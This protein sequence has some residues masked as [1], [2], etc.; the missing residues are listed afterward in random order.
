MATSSF[1]FGSDLPIGVAILAVLIGILGALFLIGAVILFLVLF[2]ASSFSAPAL[3]F[4]GSTFIGALLLLI[5]GI[6]LLVV[7][8]GLWDLELWAL[9]LSIIVVGIAFIGELLQGVSQIVEILLLLL[10]LIYLFAVSS[11][12][13]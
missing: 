13:R 2:F 10:L 11:H 3:V 8:T 6:V 1:R 7:A 12:F 9:V 5:F 4:F